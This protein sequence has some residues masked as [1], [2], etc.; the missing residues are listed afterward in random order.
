MK[1]L[2]FWQ[3]VSYRPR[4]SL[5]GS[6]KAD[7][8]IVGGGI[9]GVSA[10]YHL[11]K[12]GFSCA[13]V[14]KDVIAGGASGKNMGLP[15]EGTA[16]DF[17]EMVR[18][19]GKKYA[20]QWWLLTCEGRDNLISIIK[21]E[22]ISCDLRKSGSLYVGLDK[23]QA[24]WL[25]KEAAERKKHGIYCEFLDKSKLKSV[26]SSPFEAAIYA[27]NN[28][29]LNPVKLVRGLAK[30][31][32]QLGVKIY[33]Q[34]SAIKIT[35]NAVHTP[36]GIIACDRVFVALESYNNFVKSRQSGVLAVMTKP[37]PGASKLG[38]KYGHMLWDNIPSY[39]AIRFSGNR[40]L[41]THDIRASA[42]QQ[43][44][45]R[46]AA[47]LIRV[48][49]K[50]FPGL[51]KSDVQISHQWDCKVAESPRKIFSIC[52]VNGIWHAFG[53]AGQGM[54]QGSLAGKIIAGHFRGKPIPEVYNSKSKISMNGNTW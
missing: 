36:N 23:K 52:N 37:I 32:E 19:L 47:A 30:K 26:I 14:E 40:L 24:A 18:A 6:I 34:T 43:Q 35:P 9:T 8:A 11:A 48:L 50:Y 45:D 51:K 21:R 53:C 38:W 29:M 49:L 42:S 2:S 44:K 12:A 15:V 3:D 31:A 1:R 20:K 5:K 17:L 28:Y 13:L 39:H 46:H 16:F 7:V 33:E 25:K 22:S 41:I 54:S 4:R 27:P 10:A